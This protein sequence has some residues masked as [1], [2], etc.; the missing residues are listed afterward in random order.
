M[1]RGPAIFI[2]GGDERPGPRAT[3]CPDPLHDYPLPSGYVD[4]SMVADRR[5][6]QRW[7]NRRCERCGL[8]GWVP[9]VAATEVVR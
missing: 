6:R 5:L 8:Y 9:P 7:I 4:A 1:S 3:D 2:R